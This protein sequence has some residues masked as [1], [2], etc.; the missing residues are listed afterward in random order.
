[1]SGIYI[2][3]SITVVVLFI[4]TRISVV[5][6]IKSDVV[7]IEIH[8]TFLAIIF[9][10]DKKD[11]PSNSFDSKII[12]SVRKALINILPNADITLHKIR[13]SDNP[14]NFGK[15]TFTRP[16]RYHI[17]ISTLIAYLGIKAQKIKMN[18]DAIT[19]IPDSDRYIEFF[20][21]LR[22]MLFHLLFELIRLS[23][24]IR[25]KTKG[26]KRCQSLKWVT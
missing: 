6:I 20:I 14:R 8:L 4:L 15:S 12:F 25:K 19:F 22:I 1:M 5:K 21:T 26:T 24:A 2:F 10:Q 16:Y 7:T 13:V 23:Y 18:T 17:A 9:V 11:Q 3:L